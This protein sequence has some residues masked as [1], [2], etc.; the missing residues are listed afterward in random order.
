VAQIILTVE[1][2]IKAVSKIKLPLAGIL[3]EVDVFA[4]TPKSTNILSFDLFKK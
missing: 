4:G 3:K 1:A 2:G